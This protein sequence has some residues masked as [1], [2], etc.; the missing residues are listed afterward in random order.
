MLGEPEKLGDVVEEDD[1]VRR[2][3]AVTESRDRVGLIEY[4]FDGESDDV[5]DSDGD[6]VEERDED[7]SRD[8]VGDVVVDGVTSREG[9]AEL[10]GV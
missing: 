1:G 10:D 3:V 7:N 8:G 6:Q 5:T 4:A 2:G 9:D